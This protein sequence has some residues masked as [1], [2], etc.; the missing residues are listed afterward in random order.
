MKKLALILSL[1]FLV[2]CNT[3]D[4]AGD[5]VT[6]EFE[7]IKIILPQG[8]WKVSNFYESQADHTADFESFTFTFKEDGTVYGQTD[9][10]TENGTWNYESTSEFGEQLVLQFSGT[11]PFDEITEDWKIVS[12]S[13]SKIELSKVSSNEEDTKLLT[14]S[15]L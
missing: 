2:S 12:L 14:F 4:D 10:Y 11:T 3:D 13:I 7:Q 9:L 15:K 6:N 5:V 1:I 8:E